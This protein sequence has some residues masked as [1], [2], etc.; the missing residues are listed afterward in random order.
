MGLRVNPTTDTEEFGNG[1]FFSRKVDINDR[2]SVNME[3]AAEI[4]QA[5]Y[6]V[7]VDSEQCMQF[8]CHLSS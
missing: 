7:Y 8:I 1:L 2:Q 6:L 5:R 4:P 3:C